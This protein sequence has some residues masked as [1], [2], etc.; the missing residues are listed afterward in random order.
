MS[1]E[2]DQAGGH[3]TSR[4]SAIGASTIGTSTIGTE[5]VGP[6]SRHPD[7]RSR[8]PRA[9]RPFRHREYRLLVVAARPS[10]LSAGAVAGRARLAGHRARAAS[11][12]TS[13]TSRPPRASDSCSRCSSAGS[14]PTASRS[15]DPDRVE[16]VRGLR[17]R[18]PRCSPS[19]A[20]SWCG[21]SRRLVRARA[22]GAGSSTPRTPQWPP[23][24]FPPGQLLAA[25]GI[26][27][28]C[29]P[30]SCRRPARRSRGC[31]SPVP[32]QLARLAAVA[33]CRSSRLRAGD[34]AHDTGAARSERGG[35]ASAAESFIDLRDGFAYMLRTSWL[36]ATL[37]FA[38]LL[39]W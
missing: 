26:E 22:G 33:G 35:G 37:L 6:G 21:R 31:S 10:L 5:P 17:S 2:R 23:A 38:I 13:R 8:T 29:G 36:L 1:D 11:R 30:R 14:P 12:W 4:A 28:C 18:S 15:A 20:S 19:R 32:P 34:D 24:I 39:S 9:V 16:V 7:G 25:N 27:G 3:T